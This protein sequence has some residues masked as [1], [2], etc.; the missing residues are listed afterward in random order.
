MEMTTRFRGPE[1]EKY[2]SKCSVCESPTRLI[3]VHSQ[4]MDV[5]KCP[6]NWREMWIG[7]SFVMVRTNEELS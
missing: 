4:S 7:Y 3:A 1:I 6:P 5:P 2:V